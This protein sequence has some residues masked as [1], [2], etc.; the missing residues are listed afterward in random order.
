MLAVIAFAFM[1]SFPLRSC[2]WYAPGRPAVRIR[3]FSKR[4]CTLA[5]IHA[6]KMRRP[7]ASAKPNLKA[8]HARG[9]VP[10]KEG[11]GPWGH[12]EFADAAAGKSTLHATRD[13]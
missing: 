8:H 6:S 3:R 11:E 5:H 7:F 2:R 10:Q 9:E 13:T 1:V 12:A 4:R